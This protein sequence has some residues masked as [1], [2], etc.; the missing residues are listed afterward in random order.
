MFEVGSKYGTVKESEADQ[1]VVASKLVLFVVVYL[2]NFASNFH[3]FSNYSVFWTL[4]LHVHKLPDSHYM[5][6]MGTKAIFYGTV[7]CLLFKL[8]DNICFEV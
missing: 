4:I 3:I 1:T 2:F 5:G 6:Y 7:A 8:S